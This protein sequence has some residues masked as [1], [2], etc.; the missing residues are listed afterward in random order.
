MRSGLIT[1]CSVSYAAWPPLDL[2]GEARTLSNLSLIHLRQGR[3]REAAGHLQRALTLFRERADTV[4]EGY[5]LT[6]LAALDLRQH[7]PGQARARAG[8]GSGPMPPGQ[9]PGRPGRGA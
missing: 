8:A 7:R 6:N 9:R 3:H 1:E 4:G 2:A 5:A